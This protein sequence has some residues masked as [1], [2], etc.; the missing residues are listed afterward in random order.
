MLTGIHRFADV[1][2]S[3][4]SGDVLTIGRDAA[5][6][7]VLDDLLVS[8]RHAELRKGAAGIEIVDLNSANGTYVNGRRVQVARLSEGDLVGI[9]RHQLRLQGD[10]LLEYTDTGDF[11]L[12][13]NDLTVQVGSGDTT[14]RRCCTTSASRCRRARCSPSSA[15]PV[16]ASRR[17]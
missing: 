5:N 11:T 4:A 13:A 16:P 1:G 14:R 8:R 9:G 10:Q 7:L 3:P 6:A 17:C 12:V 2:P 15:P